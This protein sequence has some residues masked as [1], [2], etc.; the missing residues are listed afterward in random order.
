MIFDFVRFFIK[1]FLFFFAAILAAYAC[2]PPQ[3]W[4]DR[5]KDIKTTSENLQKSAGSVQKIAG[6]LAALVQPLTAS[7][8]IAK[9]LVSKLPAAPQGLPGM[10]GG[11]LTGLPGPLTQLPGAGA[12]PPTGGIVLP[13][14]NLP[15]HINQ[16]ATNARNAVTNA[17]QHPTSL[18]PK[19]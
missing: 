10:G 8:D 1:C 18:G 19:F 16:A 2:P 12:P 5:I 17:I 3:A 15:T 6:S 14:A 11:G 4:V 13:R 9:E 7:L